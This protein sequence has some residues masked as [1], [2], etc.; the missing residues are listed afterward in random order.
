MDAIAD[1]MYAD[2]MT[3]FMT[4][5]IETGMRKSEILSI[6]KDEISRTKRG[7]SVTKKDTK[8][9]HRRVVYL[10]SRAVQAVQP[11]YDGIKAKPDNTPLFSISSHTVENW[12]VRARDK[13]GLKDLRLHDL[14]HEAVSRLADKGLSVGAIANQSGHKSMQTLL[15]YVNA[16]EKDIRAKLEQDI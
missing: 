11:L 15:R 4:L 1:G 3:P 14:R 13:A 5:S 7:W 12:F 8:N 2:Q 10:S 9:G 16:S 6:T